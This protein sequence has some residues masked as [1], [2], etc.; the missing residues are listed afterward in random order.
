MET[1]RKNFKK[2][3]PDFYLQENFEVIPFCSSHF[4][5]KNVNA[6]SR[7]LNSFITAVNMKTLLPS[8]LLIVLD[9]D[10]IEFMQYKKYGVSS[11]CG[12]WIEYLAKEIVTV[13]DKRNN[14]LPVSS[15]LSEKT[16]DLQYVRSTYP[17][18]WPTTPC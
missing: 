14:S 6:V 5:D 18:C 8:Y 12:T 4:S 3:G 10:L 15:Q 2:A 1:F 16:T 13:I 7:I 11:L 9:N 17:D